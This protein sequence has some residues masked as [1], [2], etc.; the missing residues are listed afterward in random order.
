MLQVVG[1]ATALMQS[2]DWAAMIADAKSRNCFMDMERIPKELLV[3]K[4]CTYTAGNNTRNLRAG[5][6]RQKPWE[7]H[8][9]LTYPR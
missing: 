5:G 1:N 7:V 2:D 3:L 8:S 6:Q 4:A 9:Q